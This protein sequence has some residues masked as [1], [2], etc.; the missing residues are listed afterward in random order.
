MLK[1]GW[2]EVGE[3]PVAAGEPAGTKSQSKSKTT[4][5]RK[6]RGKKK[7]EEEEFDDEDESDEE[8]VPTADVIVDCLSEDESGAE[9]DMTQYYRVLDRPRRG[10][11]RYWRRVDSGG[12]DDSDNS[13]L[14]IVAVCHGDDDGLLY[15]KYYDVNRYTAGPPAKSEEYDYTVCEEMDPP[16]ETEDCWMQWD[17]LPDTS[18]SDP[19]AGGATIGRPPSRWKG[20]AVLTPEEEE[21][22]RAIEKVKTA[23]EALTSDQRTRS[24]RN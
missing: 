3:L 7:K 8:P 23:T 22:Q 1:I 16:K 12:T 11:E 21:E 2:D 19:A 6:K 20:Y 24:R 4:G 9:E 13:R 15:F 5:K 10:K 18:C 14:Q 17:P